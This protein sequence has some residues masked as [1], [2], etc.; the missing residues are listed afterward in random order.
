MDSKYGDCSLY[1]LLPSA[2]LHVLRAGSR[3]V[4]RFH[5]RGRGHESVPTCTFV[6][7]YLSAQV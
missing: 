4:Q 7:V 2:T 5:L 3:Q 1:L 6:R